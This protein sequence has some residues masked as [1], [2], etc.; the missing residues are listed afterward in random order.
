M[1]VYVLLLIYRTNIVTHKN[2]MKIYAE[3]YIKIYLNRSPNKT[4]KIKQYLYMPVHARGV[5]EG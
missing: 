2:I 5:P 1:A 3:Y 4:G